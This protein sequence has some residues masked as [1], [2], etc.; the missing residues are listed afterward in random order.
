VRNLECDHDT[1]NDKYRKEVA[2]REQLFSVNDTL[3]K[4][5]RRAN[6]K[7]AEV[8]EK[9]RQRIAKK[10][11]YCNND[12]LEQSMMQQTLNFNSTL[13]NIQQEMLSKSFI[14]SSNP[15]ILSNTNDNDDSFGEKLHQQS[16]SFE[17]EQ[18]EVSPKQKQKNLMSN[19]YMSNSD[20]PS[21]ITSSTKKS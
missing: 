15:A 20:F 14:A 9:Y 16:S 2:Q 8:K 13:E 12:V 18:V 4:A 1:L 5:L 10:C 7:I 19:N 6:V 11:Y 3:N 21:E 17:E